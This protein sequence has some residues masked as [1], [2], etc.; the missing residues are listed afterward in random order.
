VRSFNAIITSVPVGFS[1]LECCGC[2]LSKC[3][4]DCAL[5]F[6]SARKNVIRFITPYFQLSVALS[7]FF[8]TEGNRYCIISAKSLWD[9]HR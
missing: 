3:Q 8:Q 6:L 7:Y 4:W 5:I 2:L 1:L 9:C